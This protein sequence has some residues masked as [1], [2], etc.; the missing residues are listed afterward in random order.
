M[1]RVLLALFLAGCVEQGSPAGE[2]VGSEAQDLSFGG[3][4]VPGPDGWGP[5]D[6]VGNGNTQGYGTRLR[7]ALH[8]ANPLARPYELGRVLSETMPQSPVGDAPVDIDYLPTRGLPFTRHAG[9]GEIFSGGLGSQGTQFDALGHFGYLEGPW[10]GAGPFP[11][12]Q[13]R[14]YNG[15]TQAEVKPAPDGPLQRLGVEKAPPILTSA[16]LLDAEAYRGRPLDPGERVTAADIKGM[17]AAQK[18]SLRGIL[19]GDAV[20][21]RTGWGR[22]WTDPAPNPLFTA[23]Y[24]EGPGLAVD[25]QEY[26]ASRHVVLMAL[27]N[28]FTDPVRAC[29]FVGACAPPPGTQPGLPFNVHHNNLTQH[30]IYQMQN[31]A[32]DELADDGVDLSCTVV[33]P[34]RILGAAGSAVRPIAVGAPR[35]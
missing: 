27:D 1:R 13:A 17:L 18:L 7:C 30:G 4:P 8:L 10:P 23:Y 15:F 29:Q 31:L 22:L 33:L 35:H 24:A 6:E 19:P 12:D 32:L 26:L 28:P 2:P 20:Y 16:V 9:N 5:G 25:A 3:V 11:A 34:L 14:Y 21:I